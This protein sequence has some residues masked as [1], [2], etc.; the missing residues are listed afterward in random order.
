[1]K[2]IILASLMLVAFITL[3]SC[4]SDDSNGSSTTFKVDGVTYTLPPAQGIV[5]VVSPGAY[6]LNG[7]IYNR[8]TI[9]INGIKGMTDA[10]TL[11]FDLFLKNGESLAGTYQISTDQDEDTFTSIDN[12]LGSDVRVCIGWTSLI[13]TTKIATQEIRSGNAPTGTVQIISNGENNYTIKFNGNF[14]TISQ[15][16]DIPVNLNITGAVSNGS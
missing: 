4:S 15:T 12:I 3:F 2:K 13:A 5:N 8:N 7:N 11:T 16:S 1:M 10:A 14:K 9:I 6:E